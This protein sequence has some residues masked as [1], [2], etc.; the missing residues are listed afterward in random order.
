MAS[1]IVIRAYGGSDVLVCEDTDSS[2]PAAGQ[3]RIRQTGIGVNFHDVYV[4]SGLY[5]TLSLPG[6]P[7]C[8]AVGIV[9]EIGPGVEGFAIGDRVAY[10]TGEYGAY[11]SH[12]VLDAGV[13]LKVPDG[14]E[15]MLV[16]T[17]LLRAMTV[18]M[19]ITQVA[20]VRPGDT[21]LVQAAAGGV[22]RLLCQWA[23]HIGATV[24]GTVGSPAKAEQAKAAGCTHPILYREVDFVEAVKD[25]TGGIGVDVAY[26]SV[27]KDTFY[28]SLEALKPT[29]HLVNFGQSSGPV[30][31]AGDAPA[32]VQVADCQP[33]DPVSLHGEPR[34][35]SGRGDIGLRGARQRL[36]EGGQ[37]TEHPSGGGCPGT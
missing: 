8:E 10:V 31:A 13:A 34:G 11:A 23:S 3:L 30:G 26:D 2:A 14:V 32:G 22:G 20:K 18:D 16:A 5:K 27:G 9:E 17:N 29:G 12:R 28:G 7:G 15:D 21:I 36:L 33:P 6:I 24:I 19:L 35:L 25:I 4:R 1:A 37:G